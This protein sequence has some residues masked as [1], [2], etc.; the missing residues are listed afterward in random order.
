MVI[1]AIFVVVVVVPALDLIRVSTTG[2]GNDPVV[3]TVSLESNKVLMLSH[4][5]I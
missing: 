3:F 1:T 5:R 2:V 4:F